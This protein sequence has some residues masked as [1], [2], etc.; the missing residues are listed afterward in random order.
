MKVERR[1]SVTWESPLRHHEI[2]GGFH[3]A[4]SFV[5]TLVYR[6]SIEIHFT[7]YEATMIYRETRTEMFGEN[8]LPRNPPPSMS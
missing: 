1:L 5:N 4:I 3:R 6:I 7:H 8:A 2:K